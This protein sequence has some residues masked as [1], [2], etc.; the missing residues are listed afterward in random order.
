MYKRQAQRAA[1][2]VRAKYP[3]LAVCGVADG[4]F[5]DEARRVSLIAQSG[6]DVVFVCL[7]SPKPVSYTHLPAESSIRCR[8]ATCF[9][10]RSSPPR[11]AT[12]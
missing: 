9:S 7:G 3:G 6:A 10:W 8:S 11:P 1:Q 12:T 2:A 4:Y 5:D